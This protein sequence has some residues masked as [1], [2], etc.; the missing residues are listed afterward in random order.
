MA[1]ENEKHVLFSYLDDRFG[2]SLGVFRGFLLLKK[3]SGWWILKDSPR[4]AAAAGYKVSSFGMRAFNRVGRFMKPTTRMI[5]LFGRNATK[6]RLDVN[7]DELAQLVTGGSLLI[8]LDIENGYIILCN[9][10]RVLGLGLYIDGGLR[11]QLPSKGLKFL[12]V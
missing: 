5:Q 6:A 11:S 7:K 1:E 8:N 9:E 2:I 4:L 12:K 10:G 3:G